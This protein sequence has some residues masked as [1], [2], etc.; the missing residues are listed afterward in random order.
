MSIELDNRPRHFLHVTTRYY[1]N[2]IN[3]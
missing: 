1:S 3:T 2:V